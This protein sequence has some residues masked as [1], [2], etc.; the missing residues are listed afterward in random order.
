[1]EIQTQE[2]IITEEEEVETIIIIIETIQE[3]KM[4]II[5]VGIATTKEIIQ[6]EAVKKE[7]KIE[8][9][10]KGELREETAKV[11]KDLLLRYI[12]KIFTIFLIIISSLT[13]N[14]SESS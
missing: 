10:V 3:I 14:F 11:T 7:F 13:F 6:I 4:K 2:I 5:R 1:M 8:E 9:M 12:R